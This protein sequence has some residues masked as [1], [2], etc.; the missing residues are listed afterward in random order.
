MVSTYSRV[1]SKSTNHRAEMLS[2]ILSC[3]LL[4]YYDKQT[5]CIRTI[6][7]VVAVDVSQTGV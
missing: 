6:V 1:S 3:Q 4:K 5:V 2:D 7:T